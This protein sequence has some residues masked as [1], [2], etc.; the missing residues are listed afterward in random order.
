MAAPSVNLMEFDEGGTERPLT[1]AET[2][3]A[4]F[5]AA[6]VPANRDIRNYFCVSGSQAEAEIPAWTMMP[7]I[8]SSDEIMCRG[9]SY[10][11][12]DEHYDTSNSLP[13]NQIIYP[14][15]FKEEYLETHYRLLRED[16]VAPLRDAVAAVRKD[17]RMND[18]ESASIYEKVSSIPHF[19]FHFLDCSTDIVRFTFLAALVFGNEPEDGIT[20]SDLGW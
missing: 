1:R 10:E 19:G 5:A 20:P 11:S 16:S 12:D 8:P 3:R 6:N 4:L 2:T 13:R 7:E 9:A 17:P 18:S 14:W 15:A